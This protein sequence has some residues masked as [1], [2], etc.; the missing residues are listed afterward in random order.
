[1]GRRIA[2]VASLPR[3]CRVCDGK[4]ELRVVS[5]FGI[6]AVFTTPC[7]HCSIGTTAVEV[8][9]LPMLDETRSTA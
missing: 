1:M 7:L 3:F 9:H 8:R 4:G 6:P 2:I 5:L